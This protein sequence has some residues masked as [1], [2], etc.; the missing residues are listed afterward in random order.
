MIY[1]DSF[2]SSAGGF[3]PSWLF[4]DGILASLYAFFESEVSNYAGYSFASA[5]RTLSMLTNA[6][7]SNTNG[8]S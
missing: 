4:I 3:Q 6:I 8:E 2:Q 1:Y 7:N 5:L